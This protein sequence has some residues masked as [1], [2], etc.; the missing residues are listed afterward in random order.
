MPKLK[1]EIRILKTAEL[2]VLRDGDNLPKIEGYAAVFNKN[3]ED[4]GFI[5]RIAPG[6]F[7]KSLKTSDVR[8]LF[9]HDSNIILGRI[10]AGTLDLKEDK[11]GL[12]MSVTPP[13]TQLVRDMVLSPIERGDITQQS[14]GFNIKSDEW[15]DL[16]KDVPIR[17][18]TEVDNIFDVSPVTFP[19]YP[20]TEVALRSLDNIKKDSV[21]RAK[22]TANRALDE[23]VNLKID[24]LSAE[25]TAEGLK[26]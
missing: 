16:D 7:K 26:R 21:N 25:R 17:T 18:I 14:F 9:N 11:K 5:E 3:S 6:A 13:D 2:R 19:A 1:K 12:F 10:S 22:D 15:K 24:I 4:M 8:A 23:K 20:D